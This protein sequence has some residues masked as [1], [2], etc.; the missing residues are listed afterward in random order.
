[1]IHE[2]LKQSH[3]SPAASGSGWGKGNSEDSSGKTE[4][5]KFRW[6]SGVL[7]PLEV[8]RLG[9][10]LVMSILSQISMTRFDSFFL[11]AIY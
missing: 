7:S 9:D 2:E 4:S 1:M 8:A 3:H 10:A 5:A 6:T 11:V